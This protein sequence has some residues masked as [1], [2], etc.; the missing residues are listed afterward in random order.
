MSASMMLR[1]GL[2]NT[3][4]QYAGVSSMTRRC[5][6][7]SVMTHTPGRPTSPSRA[8]LTGDSNLQARLPEERALTI[9]T[10]APDLVLRHARRRGGVLFV[11]GP[12][13]RERGV[14]L[15]QFHKQPAFEQQS[16]G[17]RRL[18]GAVDRT[19]ETGGSVRG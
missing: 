19:L 13:A 2:S 14:A 4:L 1:G 5:D 6:A 7:D 9:V 18:G 10:G 17:E 15:A 12:H 11:I 8:A 16:L 3:T